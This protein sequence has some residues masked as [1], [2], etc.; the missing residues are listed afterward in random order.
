MN[1]EFMNKTCLYKPVFCGVIVEQGAQK[2]SAN[3]NQG[4]NPQITL[5][6]IAN[7]T[8]ND[9]MLSEMWEAIN[10]EKQESMEQI[11]VH[12]RTP[13][14][15]I[16]PLYELGTELKVEPIKQTHLA[17]VQGAVMVNNKAWIPD[18]LVRKVT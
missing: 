13:R 4:Y 11:L 10:E 16:L 5:S 6:D 3:V 7:T 12:L 2:A 14:I 9:M 1:S 15:G 17:V 8:D 18:S